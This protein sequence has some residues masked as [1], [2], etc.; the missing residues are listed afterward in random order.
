MSYSV[1]QIIKAKVYKISSK[2]ITLITKTN[3]VG[4]LGVSEVSDYYISN[5][6]SFFKINDIKELIIIDIAANGE[7]IFSFKQIHPKELRNPFSFKLDKNGAKFDKLL[8]FTNKG[9]HYGD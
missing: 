7:L 6:N 8:D 2:F 3:H 4:Y 5:L 9:I 1:G